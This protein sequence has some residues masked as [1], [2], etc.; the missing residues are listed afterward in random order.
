MESCTKMFRFATA[1]LAPAALIIAAS[2]WGGAWCLAALIAITVFVFAMDT[3]SRAVPAP[4]EDAATL[5]RAR[6]LSIALGGV[7]F[8]VLGLSL[9]AIANG[10]VVSGWP[11]AALALATG[12]FLGQVS[13]ANAHELI[14][15][16]GRPERALGVAVYA[17]M[18]FGHHASAHRLVHHVWV[19][20]DRDPN[21]ARAGEGF[22]RFWLRAWAGSFVAGLRAENARRVR[23]RNRRSLPPHPY[24]IYGAGSAVALVAAFALA[25][26]TGVAVLT[27]L[28]IYAQM[29]LMLSDYVQHYGLRRHRDAAG[30]P[31]PVGARHS[32]NA[33]AWY[34][35]AMMLNA[36]RHSDHHLNPLRAFPGLR[37]EKTDMPMLPASFPVM[38]AIA[39]V[40]PLWRKVMDPRVARWAGDTDDEART[41]SHSRPQN[42]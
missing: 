37:L 41:A 23:G 15:R 8:V 32:W 6:Q 14:H 11:A 3:L 26:W 13:N 17:S 29:Q 9:R 34:S 42:V 10:D 31:E 22:Y 19:A 16:P 38:G 7:H 2:L 5:A 40:P 1:S 35:T 18:L 39:L 27:G 36:P 4:H 21:S 25:G 28:A 20:S 24:L 12:L 30:M 33:G